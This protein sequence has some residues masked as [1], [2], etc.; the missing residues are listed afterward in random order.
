M[1]T[2]FHSQPEKPSDATSAS[3]TKAEN[4]GIGYKA[5]VGTPAPSTSMKSPSTTMQRKSVAARRNIAGRAAGVSMYKPKAK[6]DDTKNMIMSDKAIKENHLLRSMRKLKQQD[7]KSAATRIGVGGKNENFS[8]MTTQLNSV[9]RRFGARSIND[10]PSSKEAKM[11]SQM[12]QK[13][14][15][16]EVPGDLKAQFGG[17]TPSL[18]LASRQGENWMKK[19]KMLAKTEVD[20]K[21][22]E[23]AKNLISGKG[24]DISGELGS[25]EAMK[26]LIQYGM[27]A[28]PKLKQKILQ[29]VDSIGYDKTPES[30]PNKSFHRHK[31][32][33]IAEKPTK[34]RKS[35]KNHIEQADIHFDHGEGQDILNTKITQGK[36][37]VDSYNTKPGNLNQ[38]DHMKL[39]DKEVLEHMDKTSSLTDQMKI[40]REWWNEMDDSQGRNELP[41]KIVAAFMTKKGLTPDQE[42]AKSVITKAQIGNRKKHQVV[43]IEDF[44]RIFCKGIFKDALVNVVES[45]DRDKHINDENLPLSLKISQYQRGL[46]IDG[47]MKESSRYEDG[48]AIL[49]A[50]DALKREADPNYKMDEMQLRAFMEDPYDK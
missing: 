2:S 35:L 1:D 5:L 39:T 36:V 9:R 11:I 19:R 38:S 3:K 26:P 41:L 15:L 4:Y 22:A 40:V 37:T 20:R 18:M 31:L 16:P 29:A 44:N 27:P 24:G 21:H 47:L 23:L 6:Q 13:Q 7:D 14:A 50:L 30:S 34:N 42:K 33:K 28:D 12:Y 25:S 45:I 46:M 49:E 17:V 48:K 32:P 10:R 43:S 8:R